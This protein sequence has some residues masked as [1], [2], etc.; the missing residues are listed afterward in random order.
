MSDWDYQ[1]PRLAVAKV[2]LPIL[3]W[4]VA[5]LLPLTPIIRAPLPGDAQ[6]YLVMGLILGA[7]CYWGVRARRRGSKL[8]F[9]LMTVVPLALLG[10]STAVSMSIVLA[11]FLRQ[12]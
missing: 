10:L 2:M 9:R 1:N 12:P 8:T 5:I 3:A 6:G 4:L 11:R 7:S